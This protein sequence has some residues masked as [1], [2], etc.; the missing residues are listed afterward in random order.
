MTLLPSD[1][2]GASD[3]VR[4]IVREEIAASLSRIHDDA[5]FWTSDGDTR[6]D[7]NYEIRERLDGEIRRLTGGLS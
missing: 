5:D 1:T 2:A 4:A 6:G 7:I 3:M